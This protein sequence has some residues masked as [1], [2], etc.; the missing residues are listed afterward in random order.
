MARPPWVQGDDV[1]L[2]MQ[3][4]YDLYHAQKRLQHVVARIPTHRATKAA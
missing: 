2:R 1:W 3:G 4:T